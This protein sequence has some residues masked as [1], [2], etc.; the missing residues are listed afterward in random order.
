MSRART[1]QA[2]RH[3]V[4]GA[5]P[6]DEPGGSLS[7]LLLAPAPDWVAIDLYSGALVRGA[8][9]A[10]SAPDALFGGP[11]APVALQLGPVSDPWDPSRPEAVAIVGATDGSA[12]RARGTRRL[13]AQVSTPG[14]E[15]GVLGTLGPSLAF[16]DLEGSRPSVVLLSPAAGR[17]RLIGDA[18]LTA[19][20]VIGERSHSLPAA[21]GVAAWLR[22]G[23]VPN[24]TTRARGRKRGRS[25]KS[26][27]GRPLGPGIEPAIPVLLV[28]G[29]DRPMRG[30]VRKVLLGLVPAS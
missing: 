7:C 19:H 6:L 3:F 29:L 14:D 30:Q 20:F 8:L 9:D 16:S 17:V 18:S 2:A 21:P 1:S 15:R 5:L 25:M 24:A 4:P 11:L 26:A 10:D 23:H 27:A 22:D 28:V 13:L 12:P